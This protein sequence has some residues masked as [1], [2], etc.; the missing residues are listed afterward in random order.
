MFVELSHLVLHLLDKRAAISYTHVASGL[1]SLST[2]PSWNHSHTIDLSQ[3][4][5]TPLLPSLNTLSLLWMFPTCTMYPRPQSHSHSQFFN[6]CIH[7]CVEKIGEP[8]DEAMYD[9]C[10]I[11]SVIWIEQSLC[12][13][14]YGCSYVNV[15]VHWYGTQPA[16]PTTLLSIIYYS[17][18]LNVSS[19][20]FKF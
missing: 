9:K 7:L 15:C 8:E 5:I 4:C 14:V 17:T 18:I 19:W 6:A 1:L 10:Y 20:K 2:A 13:H 12:L 3:E 16:V 11:L